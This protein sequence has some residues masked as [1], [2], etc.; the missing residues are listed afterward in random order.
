MNKDLA[1]TDVAGSWPIGPVVRGGSAQAGPHPGSGPNL[2]LAALV[3]IVRE[4]RWL[5]LG[6][7]GVGLALSI[8][9][10]LLTTPLYRSTVTLEV[11]PPTVEIMEEKNRDS[12]ATP[13]TWEFVATQVGLLRSRSLA[14]RV[15]QDLNL[16]AN[17]EFS[18]PSADPA[19]RL[20]AAAGEVA[21]NLEVIPPEEGT[22]IE[23][24]YVANSPQTS[25]QVANGIAPCLR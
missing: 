21:A 18:V 10:N 22:L 6:F 4:W 5:I 1:V 15:A 7:A 11:N 13:S 14:E 25:A 19:A 23:F 8:L 12:A 9:Y 3:R 2:D 20:K 24:N 16:A 17:P